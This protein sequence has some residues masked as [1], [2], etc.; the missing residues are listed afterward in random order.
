MSNVEDAVGLWREAGADLQGICKD[1]KWG[2]KNVSI[3]KNVFF[4]FFVA[5]LVK[6]IPAH[7]SPPGA[8]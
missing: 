5:A 8:S 1:K 6:V 3:F 2:V 4:F 7:Q